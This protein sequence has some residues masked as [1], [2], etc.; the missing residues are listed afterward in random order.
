MDPYMVGGCTGLSDNS[1]MADVDVEFAFT[2]VK[3]FCDSTENVIVQNT[4]T[5][6][7]SDSFFYTPG[8]VGNKL[9]LG[10]MLDSESMAC[11]M[12]EMAEAQK[13]NEFNF[14]VVLIGC[15]GS[16]A[17][18]K[19]ACDVEMEVYGCKIIV[20][21]LVVQSQLD[22]L[23]IGT[24]VIKHVIHQSKRCAAYWKALSYPCLNA[25]LESEQFLSMLAGVE[26]WKGGEIPDKIGTLQQCVWNPAVNTC[27]GE[28][29]I[30]LVPFPQVVL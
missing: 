13:E 5:I 7:R 27:C 3:D 4:N 14:D 17:K 10:G 25:D 26:R 16:R 1:H 19:S 6:C 24:S 8:I 28:S 9:T 15:G 21:T 12:S 23:L 11:T 29:W 22:E 18:P 30:S 20:P 2:L